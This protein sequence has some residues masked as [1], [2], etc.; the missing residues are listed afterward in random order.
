[1]PRAN[2]LAYSAA[3]SVTCKKGLQHWKM[4]DQ[5]P[6][7]STV[8]SPPIQ[9]ELLYPHPTPQTVSVCPYCTNR[10]SSRSGELSTVGLHELLSL[11]WLLC[12]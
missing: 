10:E 8:T 7:Y 1:L 4:G 11:V 3:A 2:T 12:I 6:P 5:T 9:L